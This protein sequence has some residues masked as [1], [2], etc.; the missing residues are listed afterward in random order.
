[1]LRTIVRN[2]SANY[3]GVA[4]Q[5]VVA[6]MLT[7]FVIRSLGDEMYGV[8]TIIA[9][10]GA[11]LTL[12]DVGMV[13]AITKYIS[14][15][16]KLH[17]KG[18]VTKVVSCAA[19]IA[20]PITLF[21]FLVSPFTGRALMQIM[22]INEAHYKIIVIA[23]MLT[24]IEVGIFV[25]AGL[26][27]G[28]ILGLQRNDIENLI[29]LSVLAL[30]AVCIYFVLSKG[31]GIVGMASVM[32]TCML[33]GSIAS[34]VFS[35]KL[36]PDSKITPSAIDRDGVSMVRSFSGASFLSMVAGQLIFYSD[37]FV[38]GHFLGATAVTFYAVA[39]TLKEYTNQLMVATHRVFIPV[40]S[41]LSTG[42][43]TEL[44]THFFRSNRY[45]FVISNLLCIGLFVLGDRFLAVWLGEKYAITSGTILMVLFIAQIIRGP[46]LISYALLQ[47]IGK[48]KL[49]ARLELVFAVLN[50]ILS[51]ILVQWLGLIGVAIGTAMTQMTFYGFISPYLVAREMDISIMTY[52]KE[53]YGKT[54]VPAL[55]LGILLLAL[56]YFFHIDSFLEL[57]SA[58]AISGLFYL[59]IVYFTTLSNDERNWVSGQVSQRLQR[60]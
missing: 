41:N 30:R 8:W 20:V 58:G 23:T 22:N 32:M 48:H 45:M 25:F 53:T 40:F 27:R 36:L 50:L 37:S 19:V 4:G 28:V 33:V 35:R 57:L 60:A 49:Y 44:L 11:Y 54:G 21:L 43:K 14:H 47:G 39:W 46:Q 55:A 59:V 52:V 5:I 3:V 34:F 16:D 12:F 18:H 2:L 51:I 13:S 42:N 56:K 38:V 6:F 29:Q 10:L 9:A 17:E 7:P 26:F 24:T 31:F 1:M 15:G